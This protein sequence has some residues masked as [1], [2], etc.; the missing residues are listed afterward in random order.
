MSKWISSGKSDS[1]DGCDYFT[2]EMIPVEGEI[3]ELEEE[4]SMKQCGLEGLYDTGFMHQDDT[5]T[6][7]AQ[8]DKM[9]LP[10]KKTTST[11][12]VAKLR[13][14]MHG[15]PKIGKTTTLSKIDDMLIIATEGGHDHM[16]QT[17]HSEKDGH[18]LMEN[19]S[20]YLVS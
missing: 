16:S 2:P 14:T 4:R 5:K 1:C 11:I 18:S 15:P 8:G 13:V 7:Q 12:D 19:S 20:E 10:T 6:R 9:K 3:N 17:C